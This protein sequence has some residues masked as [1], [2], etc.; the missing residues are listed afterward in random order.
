MISSFSDPFEALLAMQRALDARLESDWMER[1]TAGMGAYPPINIFQKGDDFV[2]I[3]ELPGVD[4][5]DIEIQAKENTIR[6]SGRKT[7][8]YDEGASMH[9]RERVSGVF[10]RTL[11]V[12]IQID[13]DGIKAEYRDGVLTL[14]I[15]RAESE[16]PR[17]IKIK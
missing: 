17:T 5:K 2:V 9:R 3:L 1:G 11:S 4:K 7:I 14:F 16:K 10:D 15:P 12:P 6:I 8:N 13:P